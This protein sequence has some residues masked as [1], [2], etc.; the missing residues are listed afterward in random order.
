MHT[1]KTIPLSLLSARQGDVLAMTCHGPVTLVAEERIAGILLSPAHW[2][3]IARALQA[4]Q[5]CLA[6]AE[7]SKC[8]LQ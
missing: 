4:A 6:A 1:S 2:E 5:E 3:A 7:A 8:Q